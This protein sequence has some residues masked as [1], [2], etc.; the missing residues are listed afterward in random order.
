[1]RELSV[2]VLAVVWIA[3]SPPA[4]AKN[5]NYRL[6]SDNTV[7][8]IGDMVQMV[9]PLSALAYSAAIGDGE[10]VWQWTEAVGSAA[11]ATQA[12]K[13]TV[14][15]ERPYEEEDS[16]GLTFPSGH[17]S[18]AFSGAA[19]WQRRY[20]WEIGAPMY[21]GAAFVAYSRVHA[22]KHNWFDVAA[23]AAIGYGFNYLFTGEYVPEGMRAS[24]SP[25]DGG[26]RFDLR[27][28]F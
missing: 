14:K 22:R 18:F 6:R 16:K 17:T 28:M 9:I 15:E 26:A 27:M 12:L 13:Y 8:T 2:S 25:A 1:M 7:E 21:A 19:Y 24:L 20:G 11:L 10:G 5:R 4:L 3:V 23:G